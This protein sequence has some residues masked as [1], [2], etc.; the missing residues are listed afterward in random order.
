M[1]YVRSAVESA[2]LASYV[3]TVWE[4]SATSAEAAAPSSNSGVLSFASVMVIVTVSTSA[5][6]ASEATIVSV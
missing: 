4:F 2:S 3:P 6:V 1:L 5:D